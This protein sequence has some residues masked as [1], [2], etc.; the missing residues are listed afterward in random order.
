[1][2]YKG[3]SYDL[4]QERGTIHPIAPGQRWRHRRMG[5]SGVIKS[6]EIDSRPPYDTWFASGHALIVTIDRD[7]GD[8]NNLLSSRFPWD[9]IESFYKHMQFVGWGLAPSTDASRFPHV[10]PRCTSACYLGAVPSALDC[11]NA[12]CPSKI[13]GKVVVST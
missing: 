3:V 8:N 9:G 6:V 11:T 2:L 10:C 1:M 13:Y 5:A 12:R 4:D 7:L